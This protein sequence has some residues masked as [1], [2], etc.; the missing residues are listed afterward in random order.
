MLAR[1]DHPAVEHAELFGDAVEIVEVHTETIDAMIGVLMAGWIHSA[2]RLNPE[3]QQ[4]R[5]C[6]YLLVAA[7]REFGACR[8]AGACRQSAL[9]PCV[10]AI[11]ARLYS[12]A[13]RC[14]QVRARWMGS[15]RGQEGQLA[16]CHAPATRSG[17]CRAAW[18]PALP[19]YDDHSSSQLKLLT[20]AD[21]LNLEVCH[22]ALAK[23]E[24][25]SAMDMATPCQAKRGEVEI[26]FI[27]ASI[28][29]TELSH[30]NAPWS[31]AGTGLPT[32][33]SVAS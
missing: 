8:L 6:E 4:H 27:P 26:K 19:S 23:S 7:Y 12:V 31:S 14:L 25:G 9:R 30:E 29:A 3:R 20:A 10:S 1:T 13:L 24:V 22:A 2:G 16:S 17:P 33:L 15:R 18:Q 28:S 5:D 32:S 11:A 21:A